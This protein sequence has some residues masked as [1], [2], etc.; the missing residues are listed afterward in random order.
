[1]FKFISCVPW[2]KIDWIFGTLA[3]SPKRKIHD[4]YFQCR[5]AS[6]LSD[7]LVDKYF[8]NEFISTSF[9]V[10]PNKLAW[11][12]LLKAISGN[13]CRKRS[14]AIVHFLELLILQNRSRDEQTALLLEYL[15]ITSQAFRARHLSIYIVL[16]LHQQLLLVVQLDEL[17]RKQF[18]HLHQL[19]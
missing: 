3:Q 17:P 11:Q 15:N 9:G 7:W 14:H 19:A 8:K 4:T 1:M 18:Y 16:R 2:C 5:A 12:K 10:S 6:R 13:I